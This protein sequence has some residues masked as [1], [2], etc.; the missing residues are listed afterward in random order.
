VVFIFLCFCDL[1]MFL[2]VLSVV[3]VYSLLSSSLVA[4]FSITSV[5]SELSYVRF[6][7]DL[8]VEVVLLSLHLSLLQ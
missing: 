1:L 2:L 4:C 3:H 6:L 8:C 7:S 5:A